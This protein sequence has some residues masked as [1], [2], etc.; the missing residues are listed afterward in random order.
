M[1]QVI[2]ALEAGGTKMVLA[3]GK[4]DGT[5]LEQVSIPTGTPEETIP[6]MIAYFKDKD[7]A[8]L[9]IG[10][11]GP[12]IVNPGSPRWGQILDTPKKAWKD[13]DFAG[14]MRS[15]L[16]VPVGFDTDVNVACLGE[17]IY[18]CARQLD[19]VVYLTIGT[20][21][22]AGVYCD[23]QLLH[24]MLHPEAGHIPLAKIPGDPGKS[25]CPF[26]PSCFEGLASGPSIEARWGKKGFELADRPEVWDL[27]AD[28]I[29]Q[30]MVTMI[31]CY[32]P[33]RIILG[34][35]V[36][37]QQQLFPL[38]RTK[39]LEKLNAYIVTPELRK[40]DTYIVPN[41]LHEKQGIMGCIS[42]GLQALK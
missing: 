2:G 5:I 32:S 31:L 23:G 16:K 21:I 6:P 3:I 27:E 12:A 9:G 7:I 4:P 38:I 40:I 22:G 37:K 34:G 11:F 33:Q 36:M 15:A 19:C 42:L 28:Y 17:V 18:G 1:K 8:A 26:H 41:S 29:A 39:T 24:G 35:G 13:Y 25:V 30:A 14:A 20:G 10:S